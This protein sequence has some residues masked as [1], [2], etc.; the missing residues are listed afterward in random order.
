MAAFLQVMPPA[1]IVAVPG[2]GEMFVRDSGEREDARGTVLLLHGWMFSADLNWITCYAPLQEAGYRVLAVDHRGHGRGIRSL[3]PFRLTDCADDAAA[4]LRHLGV[5]RALVV[6][7]S[8][9]GAVAQHMARRHPDLVAGL[10]LS[11]T[12]LH[13]SGDRRSRLFWKAMGLLQLWLRTRSRQ[14]WSGILR[15]RGL[16]HNDEVAVWLVTELDR[17]DPA[18]LAEAGRE[19]GRFDSRGWARDIRRPTAVICTTRDR[20]V[21]PE[22]QRLIASTIPGARVFEVPADHTA[23]GLRPNLYVPALL[24]ALEHVAAAERGSEHAA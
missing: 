1:R 17:G 10:V 19:L 12:A 5:R 16:H 24:R 9:G 14:V 23:V 8:M 13:W 18:A 7:Y 11:A 21:P 4:L 3:E 22:N 15:R 2:R 6:G 20:L